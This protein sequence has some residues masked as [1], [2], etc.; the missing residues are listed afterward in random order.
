MSK[1][2]K[3]N[4]YYI[5]NTEKNSVTFYLLNYLTNKESYC[6][7]SKL[8][9]DLLKLLNSNIFSNLYLDISSADDLSFIYNEFMNHF[10]IWFPK[11]VSI[12][13]RNL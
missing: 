12:I 13:N 11:R 2:N 3:S 1:R 7:K 9:Y 8:S 4:R 5:I 10:D 6:Y